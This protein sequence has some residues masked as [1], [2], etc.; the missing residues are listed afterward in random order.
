[1]HCMSS[2]VYV[3]VTDTDNL[4]YVTSLN[5]H[6]MPFIRYC[7]GDVGRLIFNSKCKCG[8]KNPILKLIHGRN[9][10]LIINQ[11][12]DT[13]HSYTVTQIVNNINYIYD[14]LIIQYKIFQLSYS[15][16]LF[17]LVLE[18]AGYEK[19]ITEIILAKMKKR[20]GEEVNVKIK[21]C[22]ALFPNENTGKLATF[23]SN[24]KSNI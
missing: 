18:S 14:G 8:N 20:F 5:N 22:D 3:E 6:I 11:N 19:I 15:E 16:F 1:M 10:D 13:L 9:N 24:V 2:N 7:T 4:I 23:I 12:G 17:M 21:Y